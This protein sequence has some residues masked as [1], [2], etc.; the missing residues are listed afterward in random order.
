[1][2]KKNVFLPWHKNKLKKILFLIKK[3]LFHMHYY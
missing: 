3:K 1:M 2:K